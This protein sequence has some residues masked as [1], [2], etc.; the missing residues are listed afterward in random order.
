MKILVLTLSFGSGHVRAARAISEEL[1]RRAPQA[2]VRLV[3]AL[4]R[5]RLLFRA[6]YVW[7]YWAMVRRAPALW[8]RFFERRV[9][10]KHE[11]TAPAWAFRYGCREVFIEIQEFKP[12][13][14]IAAE[15]AACEMAVIAKRLG[16]SSARVINVI[17]DHEAEPV[18]VKR[19]VDLFA[20]A[21]ER[22]RGQLCEW[23]AAAEKI[24]VTG[25][26]TDAEFT[27]SHDALATREKLGIEDEKPLV[28]LM[29]GGQG[30]TRMDLIAEA[31][32]EGGV[33][34]HLVA[35]AGRDARVQR[36]LNRIR[37]GGETKLH[38]IGWT[39][40][41][42]KLMQAASVLITKP[43]GLTLA[44]AALCGLPV[45]MFNGIPGPETVNAERFA[46]MG[47]G[48][49]TNDVSETVSAV[50]NLLRD[51]RTRAAMSS[52]SRQLAQPHA[53][54][55]VA[56]LALGESDEDVMKMKQRMTA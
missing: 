33:P 39:K 28:L 24:V 20:V 3:D 52:R 7:P 36:R 55:G 18:W 15:V 31:L 21:D 2:E 10:K 37:R 17:T 56:R 12:D 41:V 9:A 6:F 16:L 5:C 48:I 23:G 46:S 50:E 30:P 19:E 29:G 22:V 49:I 34:F 54:S 53:A 47:A 32:C 25:I 1:K 43:G 42:A 45:V 26:P 51:E 35:I 44:E 8:K 40:E 14:I 4:A 27:A 13:T 38:V 11:Q